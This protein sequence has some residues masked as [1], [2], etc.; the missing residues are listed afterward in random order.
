MDWTFAEINERA[1]SGVDLN[2][3]EIIGRGTPRATSE[4]RRSRTRGVC[5]V[6]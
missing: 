5:G 4:L 3:G 1:A 6:G 2:P